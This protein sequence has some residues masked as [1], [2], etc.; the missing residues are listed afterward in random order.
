MEEN[1]PMFIQR[2]L[3]WFLVHTVVGAWNFIYIKRIEYINWTGDVIPNLLGCLEMFPLILFMWTEIHC[4]LKCD[5][6]F[7]HYGR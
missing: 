2:Q 5:I 1:L 6:N 7:V 3:Y 4:V